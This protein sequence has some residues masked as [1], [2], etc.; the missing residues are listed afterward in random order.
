MLER[1]KTYTMVHCGSLCRVEIEN[2]ADGV[3]IA[4]SGEFGGMG[5]FMMRFDADTG[6]GKGDYIGSNIIISDVSLLTT[7]I[8]S[9]EYVSPEEIADLIASN[10]SAKGTREY[11]EAILQRLAKMDPDFD[12]TLADLAFNVVRNSKG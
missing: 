8:L 12:V 6:E 4:S 10:S 5:P 7:L 3:A 1:G 9:E 2:V 11:I